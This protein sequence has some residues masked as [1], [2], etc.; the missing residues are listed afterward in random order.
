[1]TPFGTR[2]TRSVCPS[3]RTCVNAQLVRGAHAENGRGISPVFYWSIVPGRF[4]GCDEDGFV[5]STTG[6]TIEKN[7]LGEVP[8][9][10]SMAELSDVAE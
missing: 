1:M 4:C 8:H 9:V 7:A 5:L 10:A 2:A 6:G 3:G